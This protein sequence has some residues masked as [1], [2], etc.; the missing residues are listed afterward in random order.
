MTIEMQILGN[1]SWNRA[2][3]LQG[4]GVSLS[5]AE[6][7]GVMLLLAGTLTAVSAAILEMGHLFFARISKRAS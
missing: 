7:S 4:L 1:W 3:D 5:P 2:I 6:F